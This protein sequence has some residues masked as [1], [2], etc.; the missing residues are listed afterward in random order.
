MI[1]QKGENS[2]DLEKIFAEALALSVNSNNDALAGGRRVSN[3]ESL[4]DVDTSKPEEDIS[5]K[6]HK[7][8]EC[9]S[10]LNKVR[11][12][13]MD[14]LND[15]KEKVKKLTIIINCIDKN[16]YLLLFYFYYYYHYL[17]TSR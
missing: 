17:D 10:N 4:L 3:A 15:L 2:D 1:L 14:T 9:L 8:E 6:L 11:K 12:E 13:R 16:K 5:T 7:I